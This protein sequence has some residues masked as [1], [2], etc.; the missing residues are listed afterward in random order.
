MIPM[1]T[2]LT[3]IVEDV[4]DPSRMGRVRV[5]WVGV[6]TDNK[7][8]LPTDALPWCNVMGSIYSA[9]I[10]G[11]GMAPVG[12]VA[13]TM[14]FGFPIDDGMQEFM[15]I[16]TIAGNRSVYINPSFGFNDPNGEYPRAGVTGDINK[17]AG[18]NADT[19]TNLSAVDP[20]ADAISS[21]I[22]GAKDP[23]VPEKTLDTEAYKDTPWMPVAQSQIGINEADNADTVKQYHAIGGGLM[24]EPTVAWC[25]AFV[26]WCLD[27]V[28]IKGTR[29]A[30]ARSYL[31]YGKS[32]GTTNVPFGAIAVFG[33][34]NS[35]SGHVA[36]VLEDKGDK[37]VCVGG[38]QS[39][40]SHR[41]GGQV[42][43]TTI[44][45]KGSLVLLDCVMP[46]NLQGK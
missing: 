15:I 22:P 9:S 33:V 40:K 14:V 38:N 39:D 7:S 32:V 44:P 17:R 29:S 4:M 36:F 43:K 37:L 21:E 34:P 16:G 35:G 41:S 30:S 23:T 28:G 12:M 42:S 31:K 6:H 20:N 45:K 25:A 46:T 26:G 3:G 8:K 5:R 24:R 19:G 2:F 27:K 18:G 10:S 11:V 1:T 13:G